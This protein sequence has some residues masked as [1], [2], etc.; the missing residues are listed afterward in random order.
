MSWLT[1][2]NFDV[3]EKQGTYSINAGMWGVTIGGGET[4]DAWSAIPEDAWPSVVPVDSA[5]DDAAPAAASI[6]RA[7]RGLT[8]AAL[9][10]LCIYA[11]QTGELLANTPLPAAPVFD[12][13]I[14]AARRL[15]ICRE[16]GVVMCLGEKGQ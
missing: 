3:P 5:P 4:H 2:R 15:Y 11:K 13:I 14:A 9:P 10:R 12:G 6:D 1:E 8:G 7:Q 16:D